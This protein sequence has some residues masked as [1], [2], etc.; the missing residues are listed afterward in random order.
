MFFGSCFFAGIKRSESSAPDP[1]PSDAQLVDR[2]PARAQPMSAAWQ[3]SSI[4]DAQAIGRPP[5]R[6][7]PASAAGPAR[8]TPRVAQPRQVNAVASS[9][10]VQLDSGRET[11]APAPHA[12]PSFSPNV[13]SKPLPPTPRAQR[14]APPPEPIPLPSPVKPPPVYTKPEYHKIRHTR[15]AIR[16]EGPAYVLARPFPSRI[17]PLSSHKEP[18]KPPAVRRERLR[19]ERRHDIDESWLDLR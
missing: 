7:A 8:G 6:A 11:S 14:Y 19:K 5:T 17:A 9:S 2:Q 4:L 12:P 1:W 13:V 10:R 15:V 16:V 3:P 18:R